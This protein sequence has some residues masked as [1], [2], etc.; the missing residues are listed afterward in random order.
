MR[1]QTAL[2][3]RL[4]ALQP[5]YF[6]IMNESVNHGGYFEGKESH[7]KVTL[8]SDV[9]Q[10]LGKA[11]RHQKV[12]GLVGQ[13]LTDKT[14]HALALHTYTP[15]EWTGHRPDSPACAHAAKTA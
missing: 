3:T 7:F 10:G 11:A 1:I 9:F 5:S 6:E 8:V 12:Y 15:D 13:L 14:I 2:E 4:Q